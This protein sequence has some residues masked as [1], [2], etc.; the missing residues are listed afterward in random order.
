M[1][2]G[3]FSIY[4][5]R[6]NLLQL[7]KS[8]I[9]FTFGG[10]N[11]MIDYNHIY[12][13]FL[14]GHLHPLYVYMYPGLIR[15][16]SR[17]LGDNLSYMA[18]DCVQDSILSTY[19][20]R[21][22]MDSLERWRSWLLISIRNRSLEIIRKASYAGAYGEELSKNEEQVESDISLTLIEQE[23]FDEI[24]AA[25]ESLPE[26][27]R[28]LFRLSFEEGLKNAEIADLLSVAEITVKKRKA[29]LLAILRDK[30]TGNT[31]ILII[32]LC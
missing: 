26:K 20:N 10:N 16:A 8:I 24:Y 4:F 13:S 11:A 2:E 25:V 15:Y 5:F 9:I 27:Y 21:D 7:E 17:I 18:E 23:T 3:P 14:R 1:H 19:M 6:K 30:L 32:S 31:L 12:D 28:S 29:Q 22:R